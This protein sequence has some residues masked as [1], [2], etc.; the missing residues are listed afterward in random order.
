MTL[1]RYVI[2][3]FYTMSLQV[4]TYTVKFGVYRVLSAMKKNYSLLA[5]YQLSIN[6]QHR[7]NLVTWRGLCCV[8]CDARLT[9]SRIV[10]LTCANK[11]ASNRWRLMSA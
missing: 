8:A 2:L 9:H 7:T 4:V 5:G 6:E 1:S 3:R 10:C 11:V